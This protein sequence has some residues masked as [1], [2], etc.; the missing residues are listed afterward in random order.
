MKSQNKKYEEAF[1]MVS[2]K[3]PG[4]KPNE[5]FIKKLAI[6]DRKLELDRIEKEEANLLEMESVEMKEEN[7]V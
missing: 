4:I 5:G 3:Q 7:K 2:E 6:Y 1:K